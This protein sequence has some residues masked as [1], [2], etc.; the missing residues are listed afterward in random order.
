MEQTSTTELALT[1]EA[2]GRPHTMINVD[3]GASAEASHPPSAPVP[4]SKIPA[5]GSSSPA[6]SASTH[7]GAATASKTATKRGLPSEGGNRP[8]KLAKVTSPRPRPAAQVAPA[9]G[10]LAA[11]RRPGQGVHH[12]ARM[13][14]EDPWARYKKL[15]EIMLDDFTTVAVHR[16]KAYEPV[17]VRSFREGETP[18]ARTKK[19]HEV[20]HENLLTLVE[21]FSF[22]GYRHLIFERI[23]VSLVE[24]VACPHKPT[25]HEL[26]AVIGQVSSGVC[27]LGHDT[28]IYRLLLVFSF[29]NPIASC[30]VPWIA[31][32]CSSPLKA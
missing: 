11:T 18:T 2:R 23:S 13:R 32:M 20:R 21:S 25:V 10:Q 26:V 22:K 14:V 30:T 6:G 29:L 28:D 17:I 27:C 3:A 15:Y 1:Q 8:A 16:G 5:A 24:V 12:T 31:P 7:R 19:L 9:A 4:P